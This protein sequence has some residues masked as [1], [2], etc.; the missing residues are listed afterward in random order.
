MY[1][2]LLRFTR[3]A[4][5]K[6]EAPFFSKKA[7]AVYES[8]VAKHAKLNEEVLICLRHDN[9]VMVK[10]WTNVKPII[11]GKELINNAKTK[12]TPPQKGRHP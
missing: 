9:H 4:F 12:P 8:V 5:I 2:E 10:S 11:S 1:I 6:R 3:G 7:L